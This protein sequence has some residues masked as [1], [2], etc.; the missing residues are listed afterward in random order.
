MDRAWH[1][2]SLAAA[3]ALLLASA[4]CTTAPLSRI[5]SIRVPAGLAPRHVEFA[6]LAALA[7]R[8]PPGRL[9]PDV[10]ITEPILRSWFGWDY[11]SDSQRRA[12]WFLERRGPGRV[13]VGRKRRHH[14]LRMAVLYDA[15]RVRFEILD[16]HNLRQSE[17]RIHERA[18]L[19]IQELEVEIR[20]AL[21]Q[22]FVQ[23]RAL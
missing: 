15:S 1:L 11:K 9:G 17:T 6:I 12:G 4:A 20:R 21:G 16:S 22:L 14:Y 2:P 3:A 7:D 8:P 13:V 18:I 10:E 19:W 23:P 5:G